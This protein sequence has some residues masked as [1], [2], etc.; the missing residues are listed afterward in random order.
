MPKFGPFC[1]LKRAKLQSHVAHPNGR[2]H[3]H[4]THNLKALLHAHRT[5]ANVRT[6]VR[7]CVRVRIQ[8]RNSQFV[9]NTTLICQNQDM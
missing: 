4:R 6:R 7:A 1:T 2:K 3:A 5:C 9:I 8:F